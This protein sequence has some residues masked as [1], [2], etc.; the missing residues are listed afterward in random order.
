VTTD[1]RIGTASWTDPG[2]I[3]DWYPPKIPASQRLEWY[4]EHFNYVEVNAT[5]YSVQ[6]AKSVERWCEQT[7]DDFVFDIKLPQLLSR[8]R[9]Q[10]RMLPPDLRPRIPEVKGNAQ[11]TPKSE[12]LVAKRW[13]RELKPLFDAKKFGAFLLQMSPS[14]SPKKQNQLAELDSLRD[15]LAPHQ[16]AVELRNRDWV[17]GEQ[18][19]ETIDYFK[20]RRITFVMV[21]APDS[22]HFTVMPGL[23]VITNPKLAY[24]RLH[25]RNAEG[26][27]KGKT[28]AD[29][30]GHDYKPSELREIVARA[31]ELKPKVDAIHIAANNNK[32]GYAPRTAE[33]LT[34]AMIDVAKR[35]AEQREPELP[36]AD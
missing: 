20:S 18:L 8:H 14:F 3:E 34:A 7:P 16:L 33:W 22:E 29:R 27:I 23:N 12:E 2:F 11:F 19:H 9:M 5:F 17:V 30:F 35:K 1:I 10:M 36:L 4:S 21:D 13:L 6:P 32:S 31:D 26:Y 28:V 15:L 24:F 25:G